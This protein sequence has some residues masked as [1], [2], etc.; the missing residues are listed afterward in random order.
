MK[1]EFIDN[2]A[3]GDGRTRKQIRS[4]VARGRNAGRKL[5]RP[6]RT[7]ASTEHEVTEATQTASSVQK[8]PHRFTRADGAVLGRLNSLI[9]LS[10]LPPHMQQHAR[11]V[12]L[13][14]VR[15]GGYPWELKKPRR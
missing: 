1:F 7:A 6:S 11:S 13:D 8:R 10:S 12:G 2:S 5:T 4:H 15:R 9:V 3:V 14:L